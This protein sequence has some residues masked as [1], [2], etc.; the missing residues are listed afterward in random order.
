MAFVLYLSL[1]CAVPLLLCLQ[2]LI[3]LLPLFSFQ[4]CTRLRFSPNKLSRFQIL[5]I[6]I[7]T[8]LKP[9]LKRLRLV[10]SLTPSRGKDST[11]A[12]DDAFNLPD[13]RLET[14][15][16]VSRADL[17]RYKRA[18][19]VPN[20]ASP[21]S[22]ADSLFFLSPVTEPLMLLL[23]ARHA[24]PIV[25][26]GSVNVRNRFEFRSPSECKQVCLRT[27]LRAEASLRRKGRRVKRGMEFDVMLQVF[28]E[29]T[30][31]LIF[32][33]LMTILH[34]LDEMV[35]PRWHESLQK[36]VVAVDA[37]REST[38]ETVIEG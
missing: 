29:D 13:V 7:L 26:L 25:P 24:C 37:A 21:T 19:G 5:C 31:D 32:N 30:G 38:Y 15:V 20:N 22:G 3:P 9:Y 14:P 11:V 12:N 34:F 36:E 2:S 35:E 10:P 16:V 33:Q 6:L 1:A 28:V 27:R 4:P 8:F 17:E 23:L 18:T